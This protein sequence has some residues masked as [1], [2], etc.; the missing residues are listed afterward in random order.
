VLIGSEKVSNSRQITHLHIHLLK[1]HTTKFIPH[2][3]QDH[4]LSFQI[5]Q[6]GYPFPFNHKITINEWCRDILDQ[7]LQ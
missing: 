3:P 7:M 6:L 2:I 5:I 4:L 1:H